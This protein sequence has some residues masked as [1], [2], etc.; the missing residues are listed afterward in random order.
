MV[1]SRGLLTL[2]TTTINPT[3]NFG[4]WEGW[5]P[6]CVVGKGSVSTSYATMRGASSTNKDPDGATMVVS[7]TSKH[8]GRLTPSGST[9]TSTDPKLDQL[10]NM[11]RYDLRSDK[12][13]YSSHPSL[14][15]A[16]GANLVELFSNSPV[17]WMCYN[18]N[19]SGS[20]DGSSDNLESWNWDQHAVYLANVA[21]YA[22][23]HWGVNHFDVSTMSNVIPFLRSELN[24]RGLTS[25]IVSASDEEETYDLAVSTFGS[26]TST[27]LADIARG[28]ET[29]GNSEY[30]EG[31]ATGASLVSNLM[32]DFVWLHPTRTIGAPSQKYFVLAQFTRHIRP[33][34]RIIDGGS[35]YTVSAYDA[36]AK[37]LVIV[38]VN[39]AAAQI[40]NFDLSRFTRRVVNGALVQRWATQIGTSG[41]Q[42]TAFNDTFI[43]GTKFL[44]SGVVI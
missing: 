39:T 23:T 19:P 24:S 42:Y 36:T 1:H 40:I 20:T 31:D 26:L 18:L 41:T 2:A 30:G 34:M 17:W 33:G 14:A 22:A 35:S 16:R 4:T 38:A 25:T 12:F 21:Q 28:K 11:M 13:C 29:S 44:V 43:S 10:R 37:K 27:A 9:W 6:P 32:L 15:I 8:R 3:A 7:R 5:A